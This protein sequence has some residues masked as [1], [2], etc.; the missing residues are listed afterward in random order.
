MPS[1]TSLSASEPINDKAPYRF[2]TLLAIKTLK[3]IRPRKS[4]VLMLTDKICVKYGRG[5]HL[6]EASALRFIAQHTSI[7]VPRVLCAFT[8][9]ECTYIAMKRIK[10]DILGRGWVFRSEKSKTK[11]LAQL[12]NMIR[13]MRQLKPPEGMG[14][15]SV[16]GVSIFDD[17]IP[18][19][20]LR[21]GPFDT[22]QDFHRHLRRGEDFDPEQTLLPDAEDLRKYHSK[23]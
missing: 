12:S 2:L 6:S 1:T 3:R 18:G 4:Y 13:E 23:N 21:H 5:R 11:L 9:K 19:P 15:S 16:D 17:R 22:I 20:T 8:Q 7:P 10:G 14:I